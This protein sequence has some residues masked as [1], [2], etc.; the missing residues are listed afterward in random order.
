MT[1]KDLA[2]LHAR[3]YQH[4]RAWSAK[5]FELLLAEEP[6]FIING[7]VGFIIGRVVADEAEVLMVTVEPR[8][9]GVGHGRT[10]LAAYEYAA[11]QA[12]AEVSF[13]EVAED[14]APALA[15]YAAQG[16][17]EAGRRPKYYKRPDGHA[18]ALVLKRPLKLA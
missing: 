13:L 18:D 4:G 9:Q 8:Q 17:R 11:A 5:E 10:L 2:A 15:L 1:P 3:A 6:T 7:P 12:G 14:N 16:Y